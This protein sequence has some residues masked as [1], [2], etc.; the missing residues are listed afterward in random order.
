M[1]DILVE[2]HDYG[3]IIYK[4]PATI[5]IKKDLPNCFLNPDLSKVYGVSPSY[6]SLNEYNKIIQCSE[7]E[8]QRRNTYHTTS[9]TSQQMAATSPQKVHI[10]D[11]REEFKEK[12]DHKEELL[13]QEINRIKQELAQSTNESQEKIDSLMVELNKNREM[14]NVS[15][16]LISKELNRHKSHHIK[17][18]IAV[19]L[20]A[21]FAAVLKFATL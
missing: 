18:A 4:D 20:S 3:A 2:F 13:R 11:L 15:K 16:L 17:L 8:M 5:E 9:I 10:E 12:F 19:L 1:K 7:E 14:L 21:I 6:W